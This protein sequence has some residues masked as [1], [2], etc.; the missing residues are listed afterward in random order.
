MNDNL[1]GSTMC[2][3]KESHYAGKGVSKSSAM[4]TRDDSDVTEASGSR[5]IGT[6]TAALVALFFSGIVLLDAPSIVAA[7]RQLKRNLRP[8]TTPTSSSPRVTQRDHDDSVFDDVMARRRPAY[9]R[10][11]LA[12]HGSV[13]SPE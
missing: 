4:V 3:A 9:Y 7:L 12:S 5:V 10:G 11:S 8:V 13:T 6:V 1:M 2:S